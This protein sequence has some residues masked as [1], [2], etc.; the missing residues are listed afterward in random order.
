MSFEGRITKPRRLE[1]FVV[2]LFVE[3]L[4]NLLGKQDTGG[5]CNRTYDMS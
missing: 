3:A 2:A 1:Q 5:V 4:V